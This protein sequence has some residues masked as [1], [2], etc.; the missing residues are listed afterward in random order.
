MPK[1]SFAKRL[2]ELRRRA[3]LSQ[4]GL[5]TAAGGSR[6]NVRDLEQ[7]RRQPAWRTLLALADA[8]GVALDEFRGGTTR[9]KGK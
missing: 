2:Q 4:A 6:A 5:A 8:L 3:G 9:R 1:P 7:G